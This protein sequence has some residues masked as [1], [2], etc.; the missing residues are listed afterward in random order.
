MLPLSL[1]R[2]RRLNR[3]LPQRFRDIL[4]ERPLPFPPIDAVTRPEASA[5]PESR[6]SVATPVQSTL[7]TGSYSTPPNGHLLVPQEH[8]AVLATQINSFGLFRIY[9]EGSAPI[10][11][12]EDRSGDD[13]ISVPDSGVE[14]RTCQPSNPGNPF[15]PYPNENSWLIGDWYWNYGV[16]KSKRGF[17]GLIK[18]IGSVDFHS[19]DLRHTNWIGIDRELG[20]LDVHASTSHDALLNHS[21]DS[22]LQQ[23]WLPEDDGWMRRTITISVPFPRRSLH[24]GPKDYTISDFYRRSLLSIIRDK[25]SDPVRCRSFRFEPYRLRWKRS[26]AADDIGVYGELFHSEAFVRAHRELQDMPPDN[27]GGCTLPRR[28]VA[29]MFWS[30]ATHLTSFGDAK[31]WPLYVYFGNETKYQRCAPTAKFCS[32]VAYFQTVS[33]HCT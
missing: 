33:F 4:P 26:S 14:S 21:V 23:N 27:V 17:E 30:D 32:H 10:N 31:L 11:D 15:H 13:P 7:S 25:L 12:P 22:D 29:L 3:Q 9:D 19:E 6:L 2:G 16:Q 24:P 20:H 8:R 1:R 5:G 18:I 28:I